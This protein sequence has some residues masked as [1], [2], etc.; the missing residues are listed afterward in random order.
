MGYESM[1]F[2]VE[3]KEIQPLN[4]M[5]MW[6]HGDEIARFDLCKMGW[7][8]IN[9]RPFSGVFD[10]PIDFDL[11]VDRDTAERVDCYGDE[12]KMASV[13]RVMKWLGASQV[14]KEYRRAQ[15]FY[16]FLG[17]LKEREQD[18]EGDIVLVHYGY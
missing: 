5:P 15:L 12:C 8:Q 3:R 13:D 6:V 2:V 14:L 16:A 7:E 18:F 17:A 11:Y 10:E 9:G 4:G 1:V